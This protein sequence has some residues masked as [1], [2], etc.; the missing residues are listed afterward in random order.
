MPKC[1]MMNPLPIS[2]ESS[3]SEIMENE[4]GKAILEKYCAVMINDPR[5]KKV[6]GAT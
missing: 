2:I 3:L 5:F 1:G 6:L 4:N